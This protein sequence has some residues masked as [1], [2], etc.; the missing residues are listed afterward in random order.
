MYSSMPQ[1]KMVSLAKSLQTLHSIAADLIPGEFPRASRLR[2]VAFEDIDAFV[3]EFQ[4][5]E[6]I[7][8]MQPS[9]RQHVLAFGL[10]VNSTHP[11]QVAFHEY[12][13]YVSRSRIEH[14]VPLWYEEGFAQYMGMLH[15]FGDKA[16]VGDISTRKLSRAV[17]RSRDR[18]QTILDGV[19]RIDWHKHD[20]ASHYEFAHAVVHF[21]HRGVDREGQ[22]M[23]D[24]LNQILTDISEGA[25]PSEV[26]PRY[27]GVEPSE[28]IETVQIHL[29]RTN[30]PGYVI[31]VSDINTSPISEIT[32]LSELEARKL[33]A[34]T[35]VRI[36]P[37]RAFEHV[38]RALNIDP[39][40]PMLHVLLS[41]LPDHDIQTAFD[42]SQR[43]LELGPEDVDAHVRMGDLLSYN[44]LDV[45]T[46]E[47]DQLTH[48]ATL[49]YRNALKHDP[50]RVDAAFGLGVSLLKSSRAGDGLNYLRVAYQRVPWNARVNYFL[51]NAY[52]QTGNR[53]A[54]LY[55]LQRA[56]LWEVEN[57][58]R[59]QAVTLIEKAENNQ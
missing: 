35:L 11:L 46:K 21:M 13:H 31:P 4:T 53:K 12:T 47:C 38:F 41:Y 14:F 56:A 39:E 20:Y 43:A 24:K 40:D 25:R 48:I 57:E 49:H 29:R 1:G 44:C 42:R 18:W 22:P 6:F 54:A 23:K 34:A 9:M 17:R 33:L 50:L 28:F 30:P 45:L 8:F 5:D 10:A 51:G 7:G 15:L 16:R 2:V 59:Q 58:L 55:H 3:T 36:N 27:A 26:L 32:C 37:D 52:I 19:P